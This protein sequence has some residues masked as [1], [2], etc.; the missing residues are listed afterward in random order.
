[1]TQK[2]STL[3]RELFKDYPDNYKKV[4]HLEA[5]KILRMRIVCK[6]GHAWYMSNKERIWK[7]VGAIEERCEK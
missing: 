2:P 1:M 5:L 6:Y 4:G 3:P 7:E